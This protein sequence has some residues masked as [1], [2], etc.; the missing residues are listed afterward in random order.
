MC[1]C[2]VRLCISFSFFG[3]EFALSTEVAFIAKQTISQIN[4]DV[5]SAI[6]VVT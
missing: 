5:V 3:E 1:S 6:V 2:V 4:S